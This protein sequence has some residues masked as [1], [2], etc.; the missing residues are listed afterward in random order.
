MYVPIRMEICS[1]ISSDILETL[2][3][4]ISANIT[5]KTKVKKGS[6]KFGTGRHYSYA[7]KR[8]G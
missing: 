3:Y 7:R 4:G 5:I 6:D 2:E 1:N 8:H